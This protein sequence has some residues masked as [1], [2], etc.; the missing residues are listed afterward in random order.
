MHIDANAHTP[1]C[2]HIHTNMRTNTQ[3]CTHI[4]THS[5][6]YTHT[7]WHK[8]THHTHILKSTMHKQCI[9]SPRDT[10]ANKTW[11][12]GKIWEQTDIELAFEIQLINIYCN[13]LKCDEKLGEKVKQSTVTDELMSK[14]TS[15]LTANCDAVFKVSRAGDRPT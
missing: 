2:T 11:R 8:C 9:L 7:Q 10:I 14:F 5:H 4:H 15:I 3:T 1:K 12:P 13:P 6:T